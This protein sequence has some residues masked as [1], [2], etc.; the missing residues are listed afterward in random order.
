MPFPFSTP[1][2]CWCWG[3][4]GEQVIGTCPGCNERGREWGRESGHDKWRTSSVTTQLYHCHNSNSVTATKHSS[5]E[6]KRRVSVNIETYT[7][8]FLSFPLCRGDAG[9]SLFDC[10]LILFHCS[11]LLT[12]YLHFS[13]SSAFLDLSSHN[14]PILAVV[15]LV[16]WNLLVSLSVIFSVIYRLSFWQCVQPISPG[17]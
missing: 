6:S 15:F 16:F 12:F 11:P 13:A 1:C 17:S 4:R 10:F 8:F 3:C 7:F 14:P 5:Q 2:L 9:H